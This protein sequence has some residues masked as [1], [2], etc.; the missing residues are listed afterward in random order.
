MIRNSINNQNTQEYIIASPALLPNV[1]DIPTLQTNYLI[2]FGNNI[3][4]YNKLVKVLNYGNALPMTV[5]ITEGKSGDLNSQIIKVNDTVNIQ[6]IPTSYTPVNS[7]IEGHINGIDNKFTSIS[8]IT[9][10]TSLTSSTL[11]PLTTNNAI[12]SCIIDAYGYSKYL[13]YNNITG[14]Q[15]LLGPLSYIINNISYSISAAKTILPS[16]INDIN[17]VSVDSNN[18]VS[19]SVVAPESVNGPNYG[20]GMYLNFENNLSDP[21]GNVW[22]YSQSIPVINP[23]YISTSIYKFGSKSMIFSAANHTCIISKGLLTNYGCLSKITPLIII[24]NSWMLDF[25]IY[26]TATTGQTTSNIFAISED[27]SH[28]YTLEY[29][30][31]SL[32]LTFYIDNG[33]GEHNIGTLSINTWNYISIACTRFNLAI[34]INSAA[35][36]NIATS[37]PVYQIRNILFGFNQFAANVMSFNGYMDEICFTPYIRPLTAYPNTSSTSPFD[38]TQGPSYLGSPFAICSPFISNLIDLYGIS[39]VNVGNCTFTNNMVSINAPAGKYIYT[40]QFP[41]LMEY[42]AWTFELDINITSTANSTICTSNVGT[43][44]IVLFTLQYLSGYLCVS[45]ST[46]GGSADIAFNVQICPI[47][48]A[49]KYNI[50][51]TY[52]TNTYTFFLN[53]NI[54][55]IISSQYRTFTPPVFQ[56]GIYDPSTTNNP[57]VGY[58]GNL[59][60]T[61]TVLYTT[62][63]TPTGIIAVNSF[64]DVYNNAMLRTYRYGL[65]AGYIDILYIGCYSSYSNKVNMYF[66]TVPK[67]N[68]YKAPTLQI[69]DCMGILDNIN[70]RVISYGY[71]LKYEYNLIAPIKFAIW[72]TLKLLVDTNNIVWCCGNNNQTTVTSNIPNSANSNINR[73]CL[74]QIYKGTNITKISYGPNSAAVTT[75]GP[76]NLFIIDNGDIYATGDNSIGQ[77]GLNSTTNVASFTKINRIGGYA[78]IDVIA[79]GIYTYAI[80]SDNNKLYTAGINFDTGNYTIAVKANNLV[81]TPCMFGDGTAV[82]DVKTVLTQLTLI[83]LINYTFILTNAGNVYCSQKGCSTINHIALNTDDLSYYEVFGFVGP[84]MTNISNIYDCGG[85]SNNKAIGY[86]IAVDN[87]NKVWYIGGQYKDING[88]IQAVYYRRKMLYN[89]YLHIIADRITTGSYGLSALYISTPDGITYALGAHPNLLLGYDTNTLTLLPIPNGERAQTV[90]T[91]ANST[92]SS[93]AM[94]ITTEKNNIYMANTDGNNNLN[95]GTTNKMLVPWVL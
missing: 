47:K 31:S 25:W 26:P 3:P 61:P 74:I 89:G 91:Y 34:N 13:S 46:G 55:N 72:S 15:T 50:C 71:N 88:V 75:P 94:I 41:N 73:D 54:V 21:F 77:L 39:W 11:T 18:N 9:S 93:A 67:T 68:R 37:S 23:A 95:N 12:S 22:I 4:Y 10:G 43:I 48:I 8:N 45:L 65:N 27:T 35:V 84:I 33:G 86:T 87:F 38:I 20:F 7:N 58:V 63:Y 16:N 85:L 6:Y 24:Q 36:L 44:T 78:W 70:N 80:S 5:I 42:S 49:V 29:M 62:S 92:R 51:I 60:I 59:R 56:F 17:Y 64:K 40:N 57:F 19:T 66:N 1:A 30:I 32:Q 69:D 81:F 79:N 82:V 83:D 53:G 52:Q 2:G 90:V 28:G 76:R 14:Q